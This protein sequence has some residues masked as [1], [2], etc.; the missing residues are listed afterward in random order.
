[1][2]IIDEARPLVRV[3]LAMAVLW[4]CIVVGTGVF[5]SGFVALLLA[6]AFTTTGLLIT[7]SVLLVVRYDRA[8]IAKESL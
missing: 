2:T 8:V 3:T 7:T 1:M 5:V 4:I 6:A